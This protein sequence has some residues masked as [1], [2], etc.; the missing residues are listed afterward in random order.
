MTRGVHGCHKGEVMDGDSG[1]MH[2]KESGGF[3]EKRG[4]MAG[5]EVAMKRKEYAYPI[6]VLWYDG[7]QGE[8]S[9]C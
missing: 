4:R 7:P 3:R 5:L 6:P 2:V 8:N 1:D 9:D